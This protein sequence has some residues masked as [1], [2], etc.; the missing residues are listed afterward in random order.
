MTNTDTRLFDRTL[1]LHKEGN[2]AEAM[3]LYRQALEYGPV[4]P[5]RL[6]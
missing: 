3:V 4:F 5:R 1:A 2:L 6:P